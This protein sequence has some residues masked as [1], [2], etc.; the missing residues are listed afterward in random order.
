MTNTKTA[1]RTRTATKAAKG[2]GKPANVNKSVTA[3]SAMALALKGW[4]A[5]LSGAKPSQAIIDAAGALLKRTGTG[6]HLALAMYM[7]D[8]GAT[9]AEVLLA[10][11][12][13]QINAFGDAVR[14]KVLAPVTT[15]PARGG[16][17]VYALALPVKRASKPRKAKVGKA[18][19]PAETAP[20]TSQ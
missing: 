19:K 8:G 16:H 18:D 11:G 9:Q 20:E 5:K 10:T 7:R 4:Q 17:K 15:H 13:T 6:K 12:D 2:K 3:Q 14:S 1:T